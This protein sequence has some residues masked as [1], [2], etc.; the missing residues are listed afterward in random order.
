MTS[1]EPQR[2]T[3]RVE[4]TLTTEFSRP[5][6][7]ALR[8]R[9]DDLLGA[10]PSGSSEAAAP[11][12]QQA[13]KARAVWNRLGVE[14]PTRT[15]LAACAERSTTAADFTIEDIAHAMGME[16]ATVQA[17]HRNAARSAATAVPA[18]VPILQSRRIGGQTRLS[19]PDAVRDEILQLA[20]GN[21]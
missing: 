21:R 16:P 17:H 13:E 18:D 11:T 5:G 12:E 7:L 4:L 1:T 15:Y 19:M 3:D 20:G 6:L 14:S 10:A 9:I 2:P 8:Q